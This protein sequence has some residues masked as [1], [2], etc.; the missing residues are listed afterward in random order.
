MLRK[1]PLFVVMLGSVG[2]AKPTPAPSM[3]APGPP[4][5]PVTLTYL[6]V[7]GWEVTDGAH[8]LLFDPYFSRID[9]ERGAQALS[10]DLAAIEQHAPTRADVILVGHSH[11][12]HLL[13]VPTIARAT[14][15]SVVGT[16]STLNVARASGVPERS[17]VLA[18]GGETLTFGPFSVRVLRGLHSLTGQSSGTIPRDVTLPMS[19]DGY[20]EGGTLQ[21]LVR[22]EGRT[23]LFI[24]TANFVETELE[25]LR[26]DVAVVAV[27]LRE[28]IR[29]YSCRLMRTLGQPPLV[30]TNHFDAFSEP[31][32]PKQMDIG[33]D[34]RASL[35]RF[36]EEI[37]ACA[38]ATKV[39][40]PDHLRPIAISNQRARSSNTR[41]VRRAR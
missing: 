15:A 10:P 22:V 24:G 32:G 14:G 2:C 9:V 25:G 23:L 13:D 41:S 12:D 40:V 4:A 8:D 17:L 27:G 39:V 11:Y 7:A 33:D 35:A 20:A 31:L 38:P 18:H 36:A 3:P 19:A 37:H 6:G 5:L 28:K 21:Y 26:P 29:D 16:E 34:G 30:L 1:V